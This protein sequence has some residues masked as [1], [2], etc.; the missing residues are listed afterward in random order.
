MLAS[1]G[2]SRTTVLVS[3][4]KCLRAA[5]FVLTPLPGVIFVVYCVSF[6]ATVLYNNDTYQ[7]FGCNTLYGKC[8]LFYQHR[9]YMYIGV[10]MWFCWYMYNVYTYGCISNI[11]YPSA[12]H[13]WWYIYCNIIASSMYMLTEE[14]EWHSTHYTIVGVTNSIVGFT[15]SIVGVTHSIQA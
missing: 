1:L 2:S 12:R 7:P 13:A 10:Y 15:H 8:L 5:E 4:A 6:K 14:S 9:L 11:A 3:S